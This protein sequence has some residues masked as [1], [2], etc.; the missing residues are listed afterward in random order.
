MKELGDRGMCSTRA[1][2][3]YLEG[4]PG[5]ARQSTPGRKLE[6]LREELDRVLGEL[7]GLIKEERS[8]RGDI[9]P[10]FPDGSWSKCRD[11][12]HH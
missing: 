10:Y 11:C 12:H 7:D 1:V 4:C 3:W 6:T 5:T 9:S 2:E 8:M